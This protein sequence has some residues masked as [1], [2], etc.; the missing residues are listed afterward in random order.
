M[1]EKYD[2]EQMLKEIEEDQQ[3]GDE[4]G[5][6]ASQDEIRRMFLAKKKKKG[7]VHD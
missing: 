5:R 2:L 3:I 7:V 4:K 6:I 1:G